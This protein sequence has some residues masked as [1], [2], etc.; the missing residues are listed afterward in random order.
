MK[1]IHPAG[2]S[3]AEW[4]GTIKYIKYKLRLNRHHIDDRSLVRV[5][6]PRLR[7]SVKQ[8]ESA[9]KEW[10]DAV[11]IDDKSN[12]VTSQILRHKAKNKYL[13]TIVLVNTHPATRYLPKAN[14]GMI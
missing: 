10:C 13:A 8:Q 11:E 7:M 14:G 1:G 3:A 9:Y 4:F 2:I 5:V 12:T 6:S